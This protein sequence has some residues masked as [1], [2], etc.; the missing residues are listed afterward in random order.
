[1]SCIPIYPKSSLFEA[2]L[3]SFGEETD[4]RNGCCSIEHAL[5][6]KLSK[7]RDRRRDIRKREKEKKKAFLEFTKGRAIFHLVGREVRHERDKL[8]RMTAFSVA[9]R[10]ELGVRAKN[11]GR[12]EREVAQNSEFN[13]NAHIWWYSSLSW[14]G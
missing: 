5:R 11:E 2:Q 4:V 3:P 7:E 14:D 1:M 12:M 13:F 9:P 10:S 8:Q 6:M